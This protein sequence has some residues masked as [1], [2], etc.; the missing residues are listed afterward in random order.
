VDVVL[1]DL[2]LGM[3]G[4]YLHVHQRVADGRS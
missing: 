2:R 4:L 1:G 3:P